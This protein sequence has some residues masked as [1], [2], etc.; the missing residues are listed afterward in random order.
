[1]KQQKKG[2]AEP[3]GAASRFRNGREEWDFLW[4][5]EPV[6]SRAG[7]VHIDWVGPHT[8]K[9]NGWPGNHVYGLANVSNVSIEVHPES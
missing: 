7:W 6:L 3:S 8:F 2:R 1:V 9:K 5:L 4:Q